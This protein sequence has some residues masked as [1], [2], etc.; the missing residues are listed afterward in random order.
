M[1]ISRYTVDL[2]TELTLYF[3]IYIYLLP[4]LAYLE[5][6]AEP[7]SNI[8]S[9][10]K[11][12]LLETRKGQS[13]DKSGLPPSLL[14][15]SWSRQDQD[16]ESGSKAGVISLELGR[17][18]KLSLSLSFLQE[19]MK[20]MVELKKIVGMEPVVEDR[21]GNGDCVNLN[22]VSVEDKSSSELFATPQTSMNISSYEHGDSESDLNPTEVIA[23]T[24]QVVL[25]LIVTSSE[26]TDIENDSLTSSTVAQEVDVSLQGEALP[27]SSNYFTKEGLVLSW[28]SFTAVIPPANKR[29]RSSELSVDGLQLLSI[30]E[31][32]SGDVL[33]P[34]HINCLITQ[35]KPCSVYDL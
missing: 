13:H 11:Q 34:S 1:K 7:L 23:T 9:I 6:A 29:S 16:L 2:A 27:F 30:M 5:L 35:Y 22:E 17:P 18:V 19:A 3:N 24:N 12:Q 33:P 26:K 21:N 14:S 25:E 32:L 8:T 15:G 4:P 20:T 28:Q 31:G 10:M